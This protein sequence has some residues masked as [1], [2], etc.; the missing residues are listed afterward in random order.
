VGIFSRVSEPKILAWAASGI[1][2][3]LPVF[4]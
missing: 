4:N 1:F 3:Y 2:R